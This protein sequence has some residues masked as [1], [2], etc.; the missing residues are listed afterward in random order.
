MVAMSGR[1]CRRHGGKAA[2]PLAPPSSSQ[3][4]LLFLISER[5][6]GKL[7]STLGPLELTWPSEGAHLRPA[8]SPRTSPDASPAP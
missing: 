8:P 3:S 5:E 2:F 6:P 1:R 7:S 4:A